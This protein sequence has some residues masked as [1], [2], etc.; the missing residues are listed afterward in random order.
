MKCTHLNGLQEY[1]MPTFYSGNW[2]VTLYN[3][4]ALVMSTV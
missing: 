2:S 4:I 1:K 3:D